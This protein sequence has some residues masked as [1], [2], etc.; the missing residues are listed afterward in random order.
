LLTISDLVPRIVQDIEAKDF[1]NAEEKYRWIS[2]LHQTLHSYAL[3]VTKLPANKPGFLTGLQDSR[4]AKVCLAG[5][6]LLNEALA[7]AD[8]IAPQ[9]IAG[10]HLGWSCRNLT[11]QA[12]TD[13][14]FQML[15]ERGLCDVNFPDVA[16]S[17]DDQPARYSQLVGEVELYQAVN[18]LDQLGDNFLRQFRAFHQ[19]SEILVHQANR[20]LAK[21]IKSI[22]DADWPLLPEALVDATTAIDLLTI[23]SGNIV[24]IIRNLSVMRYQD[25]RG[26]LGITSGSHSPNI[27]RSLF[28]TLYPLFV[29]AVKIH[30]VG[31][32]EQD[33]GNLRSALLEVVDS[34]PNDQERGGKCQFLQK[35]VQL[36]VALRTWRE[37]HFQLIDTHLGFS[38][39]TPTASIAGA[40]NG[41]LAAN[42][43]LAHAHGKETDPIVPIFEVLFRKTFPTPWAIHN[44]PQSQFVAKMREVTVSVVMERSADVQHRVALKAQRTSPE[45]RP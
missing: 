28:A 35:A 36:H 45:I 2:S 33:Q 5:L 8:L 43:M 13:G 22:L 38:M 34:S 19:M 32:D 44:R 9:Q 6:G 7:N 41:S 39:E 26:S 14:T 30:V 40:S 24:P 16:V 15:W 3:L 25:I 20:L 10:Q 42:K 23:V 17:A 18:E 31:R 12:F 29:E 21:S 37:L 11:H 4:H 27:K 1:A